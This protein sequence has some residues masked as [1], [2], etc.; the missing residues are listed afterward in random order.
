MTDAAR[1][2]RLHALANP[3]HGAARRPT[4]QVVHPSVCLFPQP[5]AHA[6]AHM[7]A[8]EIKALASPREVDLP[9]FVWMQLQAEPRENIAHP[10]F[11]VLARGLRVAHDHKSSS[12]GEL[13][14]SA[15]RE[16]DV[17]LS[18]HPAP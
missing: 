1:G 4:L 2:A 3:T 10:L 16:P 13:H 14:P 6:L 7:T 11:G 8:E 12:G 15:L 9:R 18:P 5:A 17:K